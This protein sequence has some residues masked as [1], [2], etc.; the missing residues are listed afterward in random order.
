M[1]LTDFTSIFVT[2]DP[3]VVMTKPHTD[4]V[5]SPPAPAPR[6][7]VVTTTP[8]TNITTPPVDGQRATT[9][10]EAL[11]AK[12]ASAPTSATITQFQTIAESLSDAIPEEGA[13]FRATLKTLSKTAN[14]SQVQ[15]TEA[16]AALL[17]PVGCARKGS[18]K[19]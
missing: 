9:I 16:Y 14:V 1:K 6:V 17:D 12:L 11:R 10:I 18:C 4:E 2:E 15:V 7:A 8:G 19:V 13:R 3:S 5:K